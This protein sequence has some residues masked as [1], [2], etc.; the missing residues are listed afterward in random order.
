MLSHFHLVLT[1]TPLWQ[2]PLVATVPVSDF[3]C[4]C[5]NRICHFLTLAPALYLLSSLGPSLRL[6]AAWP[7]PQRSLGEGGINVLRSLITYWELGHVNKC[8]CLPFFRCIILDVFCTLLRRSWPIKPLAFSGT[9]ETAPLDWILLPS[10]LAL[11]SLISAS[12][13]HLPNKLMHFVS[14][15][16]FKEPNPQQPW[17]LLPPDVSR[18]CQCYLQPCIISVSLLAYREEIC[19]EFSRPNNSLILRLSPL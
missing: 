10:C 13:N 3:S 6:E 18:P 19:H 15:S 12:W 2:I 14:G 16:A 17:D 8:S 4:I 9:L 7:G 11:Y 5:S 1:N